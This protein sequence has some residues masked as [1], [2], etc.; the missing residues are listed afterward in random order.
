[1]EHYYIYH[2]D[3]P[4]FLQTFSQTP[5]M[6]RLKRIGMNCGV[7]YTSFPLFGR[8]ESYSRYDHSLGV[9]LIVW[10][11]T[12]SCPQ[13]VSGLLHD[14]A[15]PV[16]AHVIDFMN[17]D[18]LNQDSTEAGTEKMISESRELQECLKQFGLK[19]ADVSDYHQYPVAD[20]D[21]P[22][23]SADRLEYTLGNILNY[24]F[25][26]IDDVKA[27][28]DDLTVD[29]NEAGQDELMFR[30]YD[31]AE[32]FAVMALK[33]S[34]IY[35]ADEDRYAMQ[36]LSEILHSAL[37]SG[38]ITADDLYS[39]E[40]EVISKLN[41]YNLTASKWN[42]FCSLNRITRSESKSATGNW[43]QIDA[44]RRFID[45]MVS[46]KG[47]LSSISPSIKKSLDS[48]NNTKL[49]YWI[50]GDEFINHQEN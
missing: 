39:T 25:C 15:T 34:G 29:L 3:V 27:I 32:T 4:S 43:R 1:M 11:F 12:H 48:F 23:L 7:E 18:Y 17:G 6:Q 47:R 13:S 33:C 49:D 50:C 41:Q 45:P 22:Q 24:G 26:S 31:I 19:T 42:D 9:A 44:K 37:L 28:Y 14:I 8:L 46:G 2:Q 10:H 5:A 35:V 40:P 21:S 38:V 30:T 20:N 36:I 16:F